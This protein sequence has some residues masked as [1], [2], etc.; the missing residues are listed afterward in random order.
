VI[1][2]IIIRVSHGSQGSE[3]AVGFVINA[4]CKI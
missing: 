2:I 1:V 3:Q 4:R